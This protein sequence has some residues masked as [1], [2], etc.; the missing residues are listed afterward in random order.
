M[1]KTKK[2]KGIF[3]SF[4]LNRFVLL[5]VALS[6]LG[7]LSY[8][9]YGN[10]KKKSSIQSEINEVKKDISALETKNADLDKLIKYLE[11]D[12]YIEEQARLNLNYKKEGENVVIVKDGGESLKELTPR[13][14]IKN[15][16]GV[17]L[18]S[19]LPATSQKGNAG[20]WLSYFFK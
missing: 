20:K 17:N 6:L 9:L 8:S 10:L 1:K 16:Y 2:E 18:G 3:L 19:N 15:S 5:I 14:N 4:I 7:L 11:S 12:Q 13:E